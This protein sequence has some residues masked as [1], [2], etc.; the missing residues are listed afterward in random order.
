MNTKINYNRR[1]FLQ[2]S[3]LGLTALGVLP[4][5]AL[6][7][8]SSLKSKPTAGFNADV[9][10]EITS[11][12]AYMPI[13][14][15]RKT[16]VQKYYAKVLK[17]PKNTVV[18]LED[19]YLGPTLNYKQ[20]QKVRIYYKNRLSE[21]S[22][23]HW[24]G[25]HVPQHSDGHPMYAINGGETLVY[26]FEV[27]NRAGTSFYHSHSHEKTAT[28]VYKGLAGIITVTDDE[29]Q[30]LDLPRGEYDLPLVLQDR[31]LDSQNQL[32]YIHGMHGK[33]MGF[34]GE[35]IL[36]NGKPNAEFSV[37][38]RAY[39]FRAVNGS[40]SRIYKL[41]WDDG[42]P[43]V[44]IGTDGNLLDTPQTRPYIMLAPGERVDLWLDFSGRSVGDELTL[45]SL[46]Y[47][48]AMPPNGGM[49]MMSSSGLK[50]GE[51]FTIARFKVT[52]KVNQSPALP[53]ELAKIKR[54]T[55]RDVDNKNK[56]IPIAIS[57]KPMR[58]QLNGYS[59]EMDR[60][61]DFEQVKLGSIKKIK[62]FHDHGKMAKGKKGMMGGGMGGMMLSMA[63]PIHLHGQQF[64]VVSR[65]IE[66][67][68]Q[69][70]YE[71]VKEGFI[72]TGWKDTVL[73]MPGEEITIIKPFQDFKGLFLYHCHNL[74]HEDL[75]MM[76]QFYIS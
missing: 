68:R 27:L 62:I 45:S 46:D 34:L 74:E 11:R 43:M 65:K 17:G 66:G 33:M 22:V 8:T 9:E 31:N 37:K 73:V 48:G 47:Q 28:Q 63:H 12:D 49:G 69:E 13:K 71:T 6:A 39:R 76:R 58:P 25:L 50:Q 36:V 54:L 72:D 67:M 20:G 38:S 56:A 53:K 3:A 5:L 16:K 2:H 51:K 44:A 7:K 52:K 60:V 61:E 18:E 70:E 24:H 41:G 75:G 35:T 14:S 26:E 40:N 29:E 23:I 4:K 32:Q 15:G 10:I 55:N 64:Q 19:N 42:T 57:M 21:S 30:N 59:Y 1:N